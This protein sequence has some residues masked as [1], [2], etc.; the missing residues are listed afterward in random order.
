MY[1][2]DYNFE[3]QGSYPLADEIILETGDTV[4]TY[5]TYTN[6]TAKNARFGE[7]TADEMCFNFALY[8]PM[9]ALGCVGGFVR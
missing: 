6:D 9:N 8:Y 7:N 1:D 5:C 2:D 4:S 3:S